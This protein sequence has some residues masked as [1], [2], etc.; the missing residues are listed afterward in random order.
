M[1]HLSSEAEQ[2]L[3][4]LVDLQSTRSPFAM[5]DS[6]CLAINLKLCTDA[7]GFLLLV[8]MQKRLCDTV[9]QGQV[10]QVLQ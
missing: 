4:M 10:C 3:F 8:K 6:R 9:M 5:N 2:T 1:G 7:W